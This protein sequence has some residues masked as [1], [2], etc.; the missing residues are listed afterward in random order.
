MT[1]ILG[2]MQGIFDDTQ[3]EVRLSRSAALERG[4]SEGQHKQRSG[5]DYINPLLPYG[6]EGCSLSPIVDDHIIQISH[7]LVCMKLFDVFDQA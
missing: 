7:L 3:Q 5:K 2:V 1:S 4:V 6:L